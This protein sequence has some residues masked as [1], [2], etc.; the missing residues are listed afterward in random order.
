[1]NLIPSAEILFVFGWAVPLLVPLY[2]V[3]LFGYSLVYRYWMIQFT[4]P[5]KSPIRGVRIKNKNHSTPIAKWLLLSLVMQ[6]AMALFFYW[7]TQDEIVFGWICGAIC[8]CNVG[9]F[10]GVKKII[11]K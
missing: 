11:K 2:G 8:V 5:T 6:Q 4:P 1:M 9:I 7:A 10:V 3:T